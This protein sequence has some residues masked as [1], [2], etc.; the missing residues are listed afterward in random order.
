MQPKSTI[1]LDGSFNVLDEDDGANQLSPDELDI[2]P[3][4]T[5]PWARSSANGY[6]RFEL[7]L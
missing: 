5:Y 6:D 4:L 7:S 1:A 2:S 3:V